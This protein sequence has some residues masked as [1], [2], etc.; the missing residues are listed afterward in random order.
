VGF[1]NQ[2]RISGGYFHGKILWKLRD[3]APGR[4]RFLWRMWNKGFC[5]T[6]GIA[7]RATASTGQF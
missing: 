3:I 2:T 6:G 7:C 5:K 4:S 1:E